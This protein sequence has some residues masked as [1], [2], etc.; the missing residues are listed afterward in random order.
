M[1]AEKGIFTT[2]SRDLLRCAGLETILF[3]IE[4][5]ESLET[6]KDGVIYRD[7]GQGTIQEDCL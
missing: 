7:G 5:R 4:Q 3:S 1:A 2:R 6:V